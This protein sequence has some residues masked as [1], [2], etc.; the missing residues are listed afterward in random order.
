MSLDRLIF[1]ADKLQDPIIIEN[2]RLPAHFIQVAIL[3]DAKLIKLFATNYEEVV[4]LRDFPDNMHQKGKVVYGSVFLCQYWEVYRNV[5]DAHYGCS[6][7]TLG[8]NHD[9]DRNHRITDQV[10]PL[11]FDTYD[12]LVHLNY[13]EEEPIGVELYV[14]NATHPQV[15]RRLTNLKHQRYHIRSNMHLGLKKQY[16]RVD[17]WKKRRKESND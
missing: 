8:R 12:D 13:H 11:A 17:L 9:K 3:K 10:F 14:A 7:A 15:T 1:L 6:M 4:T 2:M 16:E 5:L